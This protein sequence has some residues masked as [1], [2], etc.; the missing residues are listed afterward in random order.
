MAGDDNWQTDPALFH[1]IPGGDAIVDWFGF[2]PSFH[3]AELIGLD[4][5]PEGITFRLRAFR[6]TAETD[7]DG[8]FIRDR[9]AVVTFKSADVTGLGLAG[10]STSIISELRIRRRGADR[11]TPDE[12][13]TC[14]GPEAGDYEI[15]IDAA[16]GLFG[17]VFAKRIT[18][19]ITPVEQA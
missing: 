4:V 3:D 11:P 17:S 10:C 5:A 1:S 7:L 16:Y 12:W 15:A 8:F 13:P 19:E 6:M 9:H 2:V 18:L 14:G